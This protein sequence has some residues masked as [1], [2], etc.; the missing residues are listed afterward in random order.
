MRGEL[1]NR[2]ITERPSLVTLTSFEGMVA[3]GVIT[4]A[5]GICACLAMSDVHGKQYVVQR[6]YRGLALPETS[7]DAHLEP[8]PKTPPRNTYLER[9]FWVTHC[10]IYKTFFVISKK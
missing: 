10:L 5:S 4:A 3:K 2:R 6:M 8:A 1:W 9:C 7:R